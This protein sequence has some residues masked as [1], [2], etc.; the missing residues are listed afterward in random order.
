M[1]PLLIT[2]DFPMHK[3]WDIL[4][5]T[6]RSSK[7]NRE[8]RRDIMPIRIWALYLSMQCDQDTVEQLLFEYFLAI[9]NWS[10]NL[11]LKEHCF[12]QGKSLHAS[13]LPSP[14]WSKASLEKMRRMLMSIMLSSYDNHLLFRAEENSR[15]IIHMI[16]I[17]YCLLPFKF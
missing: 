16:Y 7:F 17:L 3:I 15:T 4:A 2:L 13:N 1:H 9:G 12:R 8:D 11:Q 14:L 5:M 6:L 10:M